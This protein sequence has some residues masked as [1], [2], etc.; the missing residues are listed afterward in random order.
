MRTTTIVIALALAFAGLAAAKP[1]PRTPEVRPISLTCEEMEACITAGPKDCRITDQD[2][3]RRSPSKQEYKDIL[4]TW[5]K[6]C[7]DEV[8]TTGGGVVMW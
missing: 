8:I 4:S 6:E 5:T 3:V 7:S 1:R 2:G